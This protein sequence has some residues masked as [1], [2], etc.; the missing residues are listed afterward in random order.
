MTVDAEGPSRPGR[1]PEVEPIGVHLS[2][3]ARTVSRAFDEVL[4]TA[5][6][7]LPIWLVLVS[8]KSQTHGAQRNLAAS[9][10]VEGPTLTH[11]LNRME[12]DGLVTRTRDPANRRQH[13]VELTEAGERLFFQLLGTVSAFDEQIRRG[14]SA[15]DLAQLRGL[16]D[17][18]SANVTPSS[19]DGS[20]SPRGRSASG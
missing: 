2:R 9:V 10:G 15:D 13:R 8:I 1:R 19:L 20:S 5:G 18:L 3:V 12:R 4:T 16:L 17:R 14:L 7:S 11:H 6:A